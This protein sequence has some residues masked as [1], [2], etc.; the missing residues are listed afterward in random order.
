MSEC[1]DRPPNTPPPLVSWRTRPQSFGALMAIYEDN[2][3]RLSRLMGGFNHI[4]QTTVSSIEGDCDLKITLIERTPYTITLQLTY[5]F[6]PQTELN[7]APNL[8]VRIFEDARL[9]S[10]EAMMD[11]PN[12]RTLAARWQRN[13][14]LNKWLEYLWDRGYTLSK[15]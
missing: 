4:A 15:Q 6:L 7:D 10:A 8:C 11:H 3:G 9:C 12:A 5:E 2:Y 13:I 1:F 14:F